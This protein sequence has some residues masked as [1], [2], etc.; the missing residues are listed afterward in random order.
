MAHAPAGGE[1][2]G[3]HGDDASGSY[4]RWYEGS[5]GRAYRQILAERVLAHVRDA[6]SI[7]DAGCGTGAYSGILADSD[8]R[9]RVVAFD[10]SRAMTRHAR[11]ATRPAS[12]DFL[13]AAAEVIP[14]QTGSFDAVVSLHML[15]FAHDPDTA[16]HELARV[17]KPGGMAVIAVLREASTWALTRRIPRVLAKD[18]DRTRYDH[19]RFF[20]RGHLVRT[21]ASAGLHPSHVESLIRFPPMPLPVPVLLAMESA[22]RAVPGS[23]SVIL[24]VATRQG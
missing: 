21:M 18:A 3:W 19:G 14:F 11:G 5:V 7:L 17:L 12:I 13:Q 22:G 2:P 23:G 4:A 1:P 16:M 15:E 9:A 24:A 20:R 8:A 6:G 10:A